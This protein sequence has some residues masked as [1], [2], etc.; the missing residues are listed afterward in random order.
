MAWKSINTEIKL[1]PSQG[2]KC[3]LLFVSVAE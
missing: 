3:N 2:K 1:K